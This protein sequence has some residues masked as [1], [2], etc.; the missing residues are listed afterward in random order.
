LGEGPH[1]QQTMTQEGCVYPGCDN[2]VGSARI[3]WQ[4]AGVRLDARICPDHEAVLFKHLKRA[5]GGSP[6]TKDKQ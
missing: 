2:P 1:L 4:G 5:I 6:F 3:T